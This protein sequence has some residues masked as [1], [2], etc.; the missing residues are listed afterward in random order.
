M[1]EIGQKIKEVRKRK[2]LSQEDLAEASHINLR[3][4][5]RI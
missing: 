1:S 4:I 2:G 5:Q 3:T